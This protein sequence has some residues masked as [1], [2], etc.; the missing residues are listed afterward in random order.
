MPV[1]HQCC[2]YDGG[3]LWMQGASNVQWTQSMNNYT[4]WDESSVGVRPNVGS[5]VAR[6]LM[7]KR[8]SLWFRPGDVHAGAVR[9]AVVAVLA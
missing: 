8:G 2:N 4:T 1:V 3:A 5:W 7:G 9:A 6:R